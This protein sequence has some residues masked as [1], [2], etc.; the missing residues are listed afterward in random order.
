LAN[1]TAYSP[2]ASSVPGAQ[3]TQ[4][5]V[6]IRSLRSKVLDQSSDINEMLHAPRQDRDEQEFFLDISDVH[7][8]TDMA[9]HLRHRA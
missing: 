7:C 9:A 8:K 3:G 6:I 4:H 1:A 5:T 2:K